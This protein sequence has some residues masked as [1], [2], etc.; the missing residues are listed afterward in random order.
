MHSAAELGRAYDA[1]APQEYVAPPVYDIRALQ[2]PLST[3]NQAPRTANA[4]R[5]ITEKLFYSTRFMGRFDLDG[6]EW[7]GTHPGI[8][9]KMPPGTPIRAIAGGIVHG[10]GDQPN[11]LGK[12]VMIEHR[13]PVTGERIFSI[14]GHMDVV[15]AEEGGAILPGDDIGTVGQTGAAT[16]PHLHLQIDR[17][18]GSQPHVP[19]VPSAG[20]SRTDVMK[21]MIHPMD[22]IERY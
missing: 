10:V 8:D 2:T 18:D 9:L 6:G 17:D 15:T 7:A 3:L 14:Y 11:G 1:I 12:Y 16:L 4:E 5:L 21:H 19:Y 13:L 22:V 20:A